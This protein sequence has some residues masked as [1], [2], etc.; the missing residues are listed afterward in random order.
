MWKGHNALLKYSKFVVLENDSGVFETNLPMISH[1]LP[2]KQIH[3]I[4]NSH[5]HFVAD[6]ALT[7]VRQE[8][9]KEC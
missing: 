5:Q 1:S 4:G 6:E 8:F 9:I 7:D 2:A 3:S